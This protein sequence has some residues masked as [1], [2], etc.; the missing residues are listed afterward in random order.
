MDATFVEIPNG[1][2]AIKGYFTGE[3]CS[4]IINREINVE[5][6]PISKSNDGA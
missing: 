4:R 2:L 1:L 3:E 6:S 5:T